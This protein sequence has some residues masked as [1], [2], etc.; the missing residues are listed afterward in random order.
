MV[1][2]MNGPDKERAARMSVALFQ[3]KKIDIAKLH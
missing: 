3:M 2:V 1:D